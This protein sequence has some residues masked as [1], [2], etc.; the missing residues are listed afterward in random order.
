MIY[1]YIYSMFDTYVY[2]IYIY[3]SPLIVKRNMA[4]DGN[5]EKYVYTRI[6]II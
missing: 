4:V 1:I 6:F 3:I 2:D 5:E